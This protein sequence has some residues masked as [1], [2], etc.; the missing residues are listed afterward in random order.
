MLVDRLLMHNE[1]Q[2]IVDKLSMNKR[3]NFLEILQLKFICQS[4]KTY[5]KVLE[6]IFVESLKKEV[7]N[8]KY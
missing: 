6:K 7:D 2:I 5:E 4:L 3:P 8:Y 1:Y